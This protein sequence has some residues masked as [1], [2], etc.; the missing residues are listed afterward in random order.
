M[1]WQL[2]LVFHFAEQIRSVHLNCQNLTEM[3]F[4]PPTSSFTYYFV[5][6]EWNSIRLV[7][8][9]QASNTASLIMMMVI[10]IVEP[11]TE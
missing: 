8:L 2:R 3:D 7:R 9:A 6:V 11:W 4:P 1:Y 5:G 10:V